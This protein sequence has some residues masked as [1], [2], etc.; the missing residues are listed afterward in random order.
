MGLRGGLCN[1]FGP[2]LP[3]M[4]SCTELLLGGVLP[5]ATHYAMLS[6]CLAAAPSCHP[7]ARSPHRQVAHEPLLAATLSELIDSAKGNELHLRRPERY[8]LNGGIHT[9]AEV[10]AQELASM[11]AM[12]ALYSCDAPCYLHS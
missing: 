8:G 3:S 5:A 11:L 2:V 9:F 6:A 7:L 10:S 4:L 1:L 12:F